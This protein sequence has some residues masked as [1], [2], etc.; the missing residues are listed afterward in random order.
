MFESDNSISING[1]PIIAMAAVTAEI[2]QDIR[3]LYMSAARMIETNAN[4]G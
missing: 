3:P 1:I 4:K 2:L